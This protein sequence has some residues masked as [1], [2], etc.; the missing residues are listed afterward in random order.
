MTKK[1]PKR[2]SP[3][4]KRRDS[5]PLFEKRDS[6]HS[7][8]LPT[9]IPSHLQTTIGKQAVLGLLR[10][11][12]FQAKLT[13]SSLGDIY[14]HEADRVAEQVRTMPEPAIQVKPT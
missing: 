12:A 10:S 4:R 6:S 13:V 1:L 9:S 3:S 2:E 7:S 11:G 5:D 14:E 8:N